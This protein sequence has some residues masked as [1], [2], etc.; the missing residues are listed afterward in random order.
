MTFNEDD[1]IYS[2]SRAQAIKDGVL[3]DVTPPAR[4]LGFRIPVA[5]TIGVDALLHLIPNGSDETPE[6]RLRSLLTI[7]RRGI[8]YACS[9]TEVDF[10]TL[11]FDVAFQDAETGRMQTHKLKAMSHPGDQGEPVL[12]ILLPHE[13]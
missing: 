4:T 13:D 5:L 3:I 11:L 7:L 8:D 9:I 10:D 2:Y 12:T 6:N 1:L